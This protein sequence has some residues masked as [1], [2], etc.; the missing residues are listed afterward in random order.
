MSQLQDKLPK[1]PVQKVTSKD[2]P[3]HCPT[4]EMSLWNAHPRVFLDIK[5]AGGKIVCPYCGE[6]Y[7]LAE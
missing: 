6:T 4:P 2:L 3:L 7:E 1:N 5:A